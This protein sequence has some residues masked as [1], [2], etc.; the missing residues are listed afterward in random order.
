VRCHPHHNGLSRMIDL[1]GGVKVEEEKERKWREK[2]RRGRER[3]GERTK[4]ER[5]EKSERD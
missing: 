3:G 2:E 5:R 1:I 4:R